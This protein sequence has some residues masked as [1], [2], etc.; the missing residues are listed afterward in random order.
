MNQTSFDVIV[1]GVGAMGA[2]SVLSVAAHLGAFGPAAQAFS[3][4]IASSVGPRNSV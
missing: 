3:A 1:A 4:A 2:A